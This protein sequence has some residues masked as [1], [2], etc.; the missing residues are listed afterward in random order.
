M[1]TRHAVFWPGFLLALGGATGCT[2]GTD[3]PGAVGYVM[4]DQEARAA[5]ALSQ[6]TWAGSPLLP[7]GLD[8]TEQVTFASPAGRTVFEPRPDALAYVHGRGGSIEWLR[9][10]ADVGE[11]RL[12]VYG[13]KEAAAQ[14]AQRLVGRVEGGGDGLWTIVAPDILARGSFLRVPDGITE[15]APERTLSARS[16]ELSGMEKMAVLGPAAPLPEGEPEAVRQAAVVGV[17]ASGQSALV[18]DADGGFSLEDAC[19]GDVVGRGRFRTEGDRIVLS[20]EAMTTVYTWEGG[21]LRDA[22]GARFAPLTAPDAAP[23]EQ[24]GEP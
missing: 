13:T 15:V 6:D 11:D 2:A 10:G 23:A 7:V 24:G 20:G 19:S 17:Y 1:S 8:A 12:R 18:L 21:A 9:L 3:E 5:G 22:G 16:L 4:L 14:L